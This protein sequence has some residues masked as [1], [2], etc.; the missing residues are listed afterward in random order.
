VSSP[1][2]AAVTTR[3]VK[4]TNQVSV[5]FCRLE[6]VPVLPPTGAPMVLAR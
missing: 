6:A 3:E 5:T 2:Q 1:I 4:P